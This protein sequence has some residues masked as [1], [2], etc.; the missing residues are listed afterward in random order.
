MAVERRT[1]DIMIDV[2]RLLSAV[3]TGN[4]A[5]DAQREGGEAGRRMSRSPARCCC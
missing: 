5:P 2:N 1:E 4:G 3:L